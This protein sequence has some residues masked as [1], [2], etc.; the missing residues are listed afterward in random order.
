MNK[1]F[2]LHNVAIFLKSLVFFLPIANN[3]SPLYLICF[4][5]VFSNIVT[6]KG[7]LRETNLSHFQES[8]LLLQVQG[9]LFLHNENTWSSI[10]CIVPI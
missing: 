7:S 9:L 3:Y 10:F 6:F 1:Q 4:L 8:G 2:I 5:D